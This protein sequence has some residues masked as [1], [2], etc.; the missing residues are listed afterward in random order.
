MTDDLETTAR[1]EKAF[2]VP[3]VVLGLI[4][5]LGAIHAFR[6][7][8]LNPA[9]D[10][11]ILLLFS[12]IPARFD[13]LSAGVDVPG[14]SA[15]AVWTFLT[16]AFLHADILHLFVNCAWMLAFGSAVA[17]RFGAAR[18]LLFSAVAAIAGALAHLVGHA[19]EMLPVI[20]ASAAVSAHMAA[21][22]R[23]AIG[24]GRRPLL[25]A[26]GGAEI[27]QRPALRLSQMMADRQ[28]VLFVGIW[29]AF[30][31]VIGVG[32]L[33]LPGQ[34]GTIIAWEA[35]VGGFLVGLLAFPL[36]DPALRRLPRG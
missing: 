9:E 1:R 35:H 14:G 34:S 18:F 5:V 31:L 16:Y 20:G 11:D 32:S 30:N 22:C 2:N 21:A 33:V 19:G 27:W 3:T 4:A 24:K 26:R 29:F 7:L 13:A 17:W 12:F 8:L 6:V 10:T 25:G 15:A 23:F 28:I 36:F